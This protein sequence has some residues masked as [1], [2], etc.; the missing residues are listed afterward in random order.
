MEQDGPQEL[1]EALFAVVDLETTGFD[2]S[3]DRIVQMAAVVV[4][5]RG[6]IVESFDTLV[7]P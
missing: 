6:E 2:P 1:A 3:T 7:K 4:N 5:G